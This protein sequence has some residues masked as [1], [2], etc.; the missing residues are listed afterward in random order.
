MSDD[1]AIHTPVL[2]KEVVELLAPTSGDIVLD[3]TVGEGGH[4]Q[5]IL[6]RI[7]PHGAFVGIDQ[8]C[9]V[10]KV[11]AGRL[12]PWGAVSL[13]H[14]NFKDFKAHLSARGISG[15]DKILLD[16]GF[17][18]FQLEQP[19]RGFSFSS[20]GPL[21]M[22]LNPKQKLTAADII[23]HY[24][25][26]ELTRVFET[27]G[28][29][30]SAKRV[31]RL[32]CEQRPISSTRELADLIA[33]VVPAGKNHPAT[34]FFQALR[35]EVNGELENLEETLGHLAGALRPGGRMAVIS[36]HSLEDRIVKRV[37][38]SLTNQEGMEMVTHKPVSPQWD[39]IKK[40]RRCR[41]AKLR[42]LERKG[43]A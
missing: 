4:A 22:R 28:E 33:A 38:K 26:E 32:I 29:I 40:N 15:V 31:A 16:L 19:E 14:G 8:D 25:V 41:S 27:Y 10:L 18:S 1:H 11:T 5:E 9:E 37:F 2:L 20:N 43:K 17:S 7:Q 30:P 23:N 35:I 34:R 24:S 12:Q 42:V 21:D 3:G 39:E 36:F 6:P 13:I